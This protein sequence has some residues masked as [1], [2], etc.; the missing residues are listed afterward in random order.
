[1]RLRVDPSIWSLYPELRLIAI[2]AEGIDNRTERPELA[3]SLAA[4]ATALSER[5]DYPNPQ[6]HPFIA[7]WREA[8]QRS[9]FSGKRFPSSIEA[10]ARRALTGKGISSINPLVDFYNRVSLDHLVP[11]GGWDL[12]TLDADEIVLTRAQGGESFRAIGAESPV[13]VEP[14]EISYLAA[15]RVVT[16]HFVWRQSERGKLTPATTRVLLVS[17]CLAPVE[18]PAVSEVGSDLARGLSKAFHIDSSIDVLEAGSNVVEV[19]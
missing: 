4:S 14:G 16:R 12:D 19:G 8:I 7:A 3:A 13:P 1:M 17:E 5:W 2:S 15:G 9:G 18:T 11:A 6:S 10:L